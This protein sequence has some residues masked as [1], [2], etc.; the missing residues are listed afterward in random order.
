M[1]G[2]VEIE[3]LGRLTEYLAAMPEG[4]T[5]NINASDLGAG[6]FEK[7]HFVLPSGLEGDVVY[8]GPIAE[9][10]VSPFETQPVEADI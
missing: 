3:S 9:G 8:T 6:N 4:T 10:Y 2:Y 5:C 1:K 7:A